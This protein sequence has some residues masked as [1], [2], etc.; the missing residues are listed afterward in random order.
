MLEYGSARLSGP[1]HKKVFSSFKCTV[2][3]IF[4]DSCSISLC[5]LQLAPE[6]LSDSLNVSDFEAFKRADIYSLGLI[7]WELATRT[8]VNNSLPV[9]EYRL[10]YEDLVSP[11]PSIEEM[12]K[13][14]CGDGARPE[15][16]SHWEASPSMAQIGKLMQEC[17]YE[18]PASRL[19]AL[20]VKKSISKL[21]DT[22]V[23]IE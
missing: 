10:P 9:P 21:F 1:I 15:L 7:F 12:R 6:I 20:R 2:S 8:S 11:D 5:T 22:A 16:P 19:A 14:V 17:W 13:V 23:V 18:N 3:L 4:F